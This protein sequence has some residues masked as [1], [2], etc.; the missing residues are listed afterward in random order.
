MSSEKF[1]QGG[2]RPCGDAQKPRIKR[3]VDGTHAVHLD[4]E[5]NECGKSVRD[6]D[7]DRTITG[8]ARRGV[9][10]ELIYFR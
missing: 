6:H 2:R 3:R 7:V 8:E 5:K 9:L 1:Q 4:L 10:V